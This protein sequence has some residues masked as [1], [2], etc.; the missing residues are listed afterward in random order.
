MKR[1]AEHTEGPYGRDKLFR[2]QDPVS[3]Q[4]YVNFRLMLGL[5]CILRAEYSEVIGR[6]KGSL[7]RLLSSPAFVLSNIC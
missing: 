3:C 7:D 5:R 1:A 2:R 4:L 6:M